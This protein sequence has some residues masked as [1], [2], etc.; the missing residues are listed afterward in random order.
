MEYFTEEL[1]SAKA[2]HWL[3]GRDRIVGIIKGL[4]GRTLR[5]HQNRTVGIIKALAGRT[6][7]PHQNQRMPRHGSM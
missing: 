6:L 7:R 4:A 3:P 2:G 5:P 1:V